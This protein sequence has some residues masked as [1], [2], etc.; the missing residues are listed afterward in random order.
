M[1]HDDVQHGIRRELLVQAAG[2]LGIQMF[3]ENVETAHELANKLF[4]YA[5]VCQVNAIIRSVIVIPSRILH[6]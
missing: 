5:T 3:L 6:I 2:T 1:L 4:W